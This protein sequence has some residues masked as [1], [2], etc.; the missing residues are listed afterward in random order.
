[1]DIKIKI[2][3]KDSSKLSISNL[4]TLLYRYDIAELPK[5]TDGL[6]LWL[7]ELWSQKEKR[8]AEFN[9]SS[10]F[11]PNSSTV[12]KQN[13]PT[14]NSLYLALMFW[15]LIEVYDDIFYSR[16]VKLSKILIFF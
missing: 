10:L 11:L 7:T 2:L 15:T 3:N 13:T 4:V 8:L 6:K 9:L 1:M 14:H 5:S 16:L 12:N